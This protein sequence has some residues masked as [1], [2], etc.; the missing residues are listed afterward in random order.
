M[1]EV[2]GARRARRRSAGRRSAATPRSARVARE[3]AHS[4]SKRTWSAIAPSPANAA[5]SPI[6]YGCARDEVLELVAATRARRAPPAAGPAGERRRGL[7]RRAGL[8]GRPER[9][10]LP[11]RLA[12]RGEPVDERVRL[13][14]E[15]PAGQRGRVQQDAARAGELHAYRN[16]SCETDPR[17][18]HVPREEPPRRIQ[19]QDVWPQVDCG[20]YPVKRTLGDRST[21]RRRS[22]ATATSCSAPRCASA[23]GRDA[24]ARG[25]ARAASATTSGAA[26]S[27][28]T[29]SGAGSSA[30]RR[31]STGSRPGSDEL[32][33][34]VEAGQED[35]E[36]ASSRRARLLARRG[37]ARPSRTALAATAGDRSR[38]RRCV[39]ARSSSTSTA[40]VARFGSWY[41]L[42]PRS[43]GGF[44]GVAQVLPE[45]AEL[46]F[47]VVYLPPIHPIGT[48][49]R[50][51]RNN[52]L[53]AG[54]R[55]P[56]QPVGDRRRG[57]RPRRRSTP[58]SARSRT[59]S[60][61]RARREARHRDRARL[62][63]PVLA[64]PPVA[65]RAPGVVP[66][67]A[68]RHDQ[69]RGEPA[70][71]LPGHLQRQL[72]L[73]GLAR[74]LG[75]AARRRPRLGRARRPGLPRRQ[76]AHEAAP[77]LGVADRGGAARHP[78]VVFLAEAFTRP[79]MM[80]TLAKVGF[81]QSYTY[82]TWRNTQWELT[83]FLTRADSTGREFYRPN[84]FANTP[85]ILH[86]YLQQRRPARVRG[87]ARARGDALA[88]RTAS[89][90][91]SSTSRTSRCRP[92][93][94]EYL[95]SEK[96]EVKERDARRPAAAARRGAERDPAREPGAAALRQPHAPRDRER[97]PVRLREATG[98]NTV[99]VVVNLDPF[100]PQRGRSS[101]RRARPAARVHGRRPAHGRALRLADRPN[102][103][104]L[105][106]G[107]ES[108]PQ[109]SCR[110]RRGSA[111]SPATGSSPT[112]S[113]S[114]GGLL[115]DPLRGFFDGN[116][117]GYGDFR[118]LTEK[119]DYLQWLGSTASGC[120]RCTRR[121][122]VTAA[123]TSPTSIRSIPTTARSRT[124]RT[125]VERRTSAASA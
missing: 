16:R 46:G 75:G 28:S 90:R 67:P 15:P 94:E 95:D 65:E 34:K 110:R 87:A 19:I 106:P 7:V 44:A 77:V 114:S 86:E 41:E 38:A 60:A 123:T 36:R 55:R 115:R 105:D 37:V 14:A 31:G 43:L 74:A 23:A 66:P 53:T 104:R 50:K 125:F 70:Q 45:L 93:S 35:L 11:P 97:A 80:T 109:G 22:S 69:V 116:D 76:P 91:A 68:R 61:G 113:G 57:G 5:Q 84:F 119:L 3:R 82:F 24:L 32:R 62:R 111:L 30:S 17:R 83:E 96:Y 107:P 56:G 112:R 47:D 39:A 6:Q 13:V 54:A 52:A 8:V 103:V 59:S 2:V 58:S 64:R 108:R 12:G 88:R 25:A 73:R 49:N 42:F 81:N 1:R 85:D 40:S 79:A 9:Q 89:T 21:S 4:R 78:D 98:D 92:G 18:C 20:R 29:S 102:Y 124:S 122:C 117:D 101:S 71:A 99:V 27:R 100:T 26:R 120:C 72:R 10:D 51:G 63:D 33:R 121:R 118:G 48:T